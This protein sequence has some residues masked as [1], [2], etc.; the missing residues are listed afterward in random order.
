[1]EFFHHHSFVDYNKKVENYSNNT[2]KCTIV[3]TTFQMFLFNRIKTNCGLPFVF[4]KVNSNIMQNLKKNNVKEFGVLSILQLSQ[5]N[6][7]LPLNTLLLLTL[8]TK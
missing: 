1:M 6:Q 7:N 4:K 2:Q 5:V 3:I 8:S